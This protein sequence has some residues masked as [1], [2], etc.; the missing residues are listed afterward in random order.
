MIWEDLLHN[1]QKVYVICLNDRMFCPL[2]LTCYRELCKNSIRH[3]S[4]CG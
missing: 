4:P 3:P 1:T 2:G